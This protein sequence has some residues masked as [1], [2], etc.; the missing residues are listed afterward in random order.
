M[1][2]TALILPALLLALILLPALSGCSSQN[3]TNAE[4]RDDTTL[5]A[6]SPTVYDSGTLGEGAL[7]FSLIVVDDKGETKDFTI[8]TNEETL[9]DAL[10]A[11]GLVQGTSDAYGLMITCVNGTTADYA[12]GKAYWAIYEGE[13]YAATGASGII[14]SEGAV[15]KLVYTAG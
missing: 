14:L 4:S 5:S 8:K 2:K 12:K 3:D 13:D 10:V 1:K 15:Y 11:V 7:S 9:A 6:D